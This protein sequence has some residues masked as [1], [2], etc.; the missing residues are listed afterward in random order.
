MS[1]SQKPGLLYSIRTKFLAII[2]I[3][4]A[5][6]MFG[7]MGLINQTVGDVVLDQGLEKAIAVARGVA[8][9]SADPL[10][11]DDDLGLFTIIQG[12]AKTKGILYCTI[13]GVDDKVKAH[14]VIERSGKAYV[15]IPD[16]KNF[17]TEQDYKIKF[18]SDAKFGNAYDIEI[19]VTSARI[20][21]AIG[22]VHIGISQ[23]VIDEAVERVNRYIKYF[24]F[25]GLAVGAV[26][27]LLI[28]GIIVKPVQILVESAKQIGAGNF[29]YKINVK[30]KDEIGTLMNAFN[31]MSVGLKQKQVISESFGRYV[32]PEV[33][34]MILS[35]KETWFKGKKTRVTV[36]FADIRGFT[37]YSE[38]MDPETLIKHLNDYFSLMTEI[39]QKHQG[40][41]DK[42]IGD[43]I[44]V[45]F[46]SP[47]H[48]D[49]HAFCAAS[50][51]LEMQ[52][53]LN[54]F[55][56]QRS[57]K[58]QLAI[59][60]GIN[61]GEVVAGNLGSFQKMEYAVIGDNVNA[62]SRLCSAAKKGD[63][64]ISRSTFEELSGK[65]FEYKKLDPINVKGKTDA[66]E[67][68][69]LIPRRSPDRKE[70][71]VPPENKT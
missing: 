45:V 60:I 40:Y 18:Y 5:L 41:I 1:N 44:M 4:V 50:A 14:S 34:N 47:A 37:S 26:G 58:D 66:I 52:E 69:S 17:R 42:F 30:R 7:V 22:Y 36:L 12:A 29:D 71:F 51:A 67:I 62:A 10:L 38:R 59:G 39:I 21:D 28:T 55:N 25:I 19:P 57:D 43:C 48:Y 15:K 35:N 13:V 49:E 11:T 46:G 23:S 8:S 6:L 9:S 20:K 56:L 54:A 68:Y 53:K 3:F 63:V 16:D 33:L 64:I 32:A 31:E 2:V 70:D 24:T 61:T 65:G 27:A